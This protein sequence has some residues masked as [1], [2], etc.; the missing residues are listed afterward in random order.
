MTA[1]TPGLEPAGG[2]TTPFVRWTSGGFDFPEAA[3]T[4]TEQQASLP[5]AYVPADVERSI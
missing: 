3:P 4:M 1:A 5:K 2:T